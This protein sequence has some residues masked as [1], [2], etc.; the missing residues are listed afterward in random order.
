MKSVSR[1]LN[2]TGN[3]LRDSICSKGSKLSSNS[4]AKDGVSWTMLVFW[5][6][7]LFGFW[8]WCSSW[9]LDLSCFPYSFDKLHRYCSRERKK[10]KHIKYEQNWT[11]EGYVRKVNVM[12]M[13]LFHSVWWLIHQAR[14]CFEFWFFAYRVELTPLVH[15]VFDYWWILTSLSIFKHHSLFMHVVWW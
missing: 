10:Q 2:N 5:S 14:D 7:M 1:Q 4:I 6:V 12:A 11:R 9:A 15:W 8:G 3:N 13:V